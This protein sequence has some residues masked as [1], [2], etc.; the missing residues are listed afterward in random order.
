[1]PTAKTPRS[2]HFINVEGL[3]FKAKQYNLPLLHMAHRKIVESGV[4]GVT[5][6]NM[7]S[8]G[9][10]M[11]IETAPKDGRALSPASPGT[12]CACSVGGHSGSRSRSGVSMKKHSRVGMAGKQPPSCTQNPWLETRVRCE[13]KCAQVFRNPQDRLPT[14]LLAMDL[15]AYRIHKIVSHSCQNHRT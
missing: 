8:L 3:K 12:S 2:S 14:G 6:E 11:R 15:P 1:M 5:T 4:H 10:V 13:G 7:G 9:S